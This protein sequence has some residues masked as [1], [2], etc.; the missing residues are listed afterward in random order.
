M[1]PHMLNRDTDMTQRNKETNKQPTN[2]Q[3]LN[4]DYSLMFKAKV[5]SKQKLTNLPANSSQADNISISQQSISNFS[6]FFPLGQGFY[7]ALLHMHFPLN[8]CFGWPIHMPHL[9]CTCS[10]SLFLSG[11][12]LHIHVI[13]VT[14][15]K[16]VGICKTFSAVCHETFQF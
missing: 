15:L 2:K 7:L 13:C 14:S 9:T 1:A 5:W 11:H 6:H 16:C 4:F 8:R 3:T 12:F 10:V